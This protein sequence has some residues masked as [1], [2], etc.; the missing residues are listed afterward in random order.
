MSAIL[1]LLLI[2]LYKPQW[3][4]ISVVV[5][6]LRVSIDLKVGNRSCRFRKMSGSET[7]ISSY[8]LL[9]HSL[10]NHSID[11]RF[12]FLMSLRQY[13][14]TYDRLETFRELTPVIFRIVVLPKSPKPKDK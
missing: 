10:L 9:R 3:A 12:Q 1:N 7:L 14:N 2:S 13:S 6:S 4:F 5:P 8:R 11:F